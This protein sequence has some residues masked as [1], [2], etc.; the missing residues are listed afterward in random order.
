MNGEGGAASAV[1]PALVS[2]VKR[3]AGAAAGPEVGR[4]VDS[5]QADDRRMI[6]L[7]RARRLLYARNNMPVASYYSQVK[8]LWQEV[9]DN[10]G[11]TVADVRRKWSHI[12]NSYSRHLRNEVSG[13][14]TGRGRQVSRWYLADE[15]NFLRDHMATDVRPSPFQSY[16]QPYIDAEGGGSEAVDMKPFM[17]SPWLALGQQLEVKP[18]PPPHNDD[19][20]HSAL[21]GFGPDDNCSYFQFF[22]GIY[23]DYQELPPK[24]QRLFKRQ[25]LNL[26]H[27]LL[28]EDDMPMVIPECI[29]SY[30][31]D[32]PVN[33]SGAGSDDDR[34]PVLP[35]FSG[36]SILPN[37]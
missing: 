14:V 4:L 25:C 11:W 30:P 33:L 35:I 2:A 18:E 34:K 5:S 36:I 31:A 9:A 7:V 17:S 1:T 6:A 27:D 8:K 28:D 16:S 10:M 22:K 24:K 23:N 15:L 3:P 13:A 32:D 12:R 19:S 20:S 26:L 21:S 37:N 29:Q